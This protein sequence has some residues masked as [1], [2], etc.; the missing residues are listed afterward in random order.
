MKVSAETLENR[1]TRLTIEASPEDVESAMEKTYR[2][3]A[4]KVVI[5]GFRKGKA[6]RAVMERYIG[7]EALLEEALEDLIPE[8]YNKAIEEQGLEPIAQPQIEVVERQP[9]KYKALVSLKPVIDLGDYRYVRLEPEKAE[10][11]EDE[12]DKTMERLKNQQAPW[13]PIEGTVS[14]NDMVTMDVKGNIGDEVIVDQTGIQYQVL[15]GSRRPVAGFAEK[16]EGMAKGETREF[17][18]PFPEDYPDKK[19]IGKEASYKVTVHELKRKSIPELNDEFA[20][21]LGEGFETLDALRQHVTQQLQK[22]AEDESKRRFEEKA[23]DTVVGFAKIQYPVVMLE[24]E[25]EHMLEDQ[26]RQSGQYGHQGLDNYL[27]NIGK[28][29]DELKEEL[30]P[31]ATAHL[32]RSLVL[33]KLADEEKITV[34][35]EEIDAEIEIL[36]QMAG[37]ERA[38]DMRKGLSSEDAHHAI[39]QR[40]MVKKTLERMAQIAL[41]QAKKESQ[42][43]AAEASPA[44]TS[45]SSEAGQQG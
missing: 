8:T 29:V 35:H 37:G 21:S 40:L 19:V 30:K 18:L 27:K 24:H 6:P 3:L 43:P 5:P 28:T 26:A 12:I 16:L 4:K 31:A 14:F 32:T 13:E 10:V 33:G 22:I 25:I 20:K 15:Q 1:Q 23:L 39:E 44:E 42:E 17:S 9:V 34:E 11:T 7:K 36:V 41:G 38:N 45:K 2:R